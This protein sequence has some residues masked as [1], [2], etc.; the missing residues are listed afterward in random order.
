MKPTLSIL[1]T[2]TLLA[3]PLTTLAGEKL[4]GTPIGTTEGYNYE[5]GGPENN[6][7]YRAFDGDLNT[8]FATDARSYTWVGL[9]LGKPYIIDRIGWSPRNDIHGEKRVQLGVFQGANSPDWLDAV[10]L[11]L[12]TDKGTIGLMSYADIDCSRGFRY[13]RYVST[14]DSRCNIAEIEFYGTEGNGDDSRL[15]QVTNLPTV[16]INTVNAQEPYDKEHDITSN[17]IIIAD[18]KTNVDKPATIRE[19]GNFSRTFP[20]KPW[21]IKFDKKQ[22]VLDAPAKAKKWTLINNYGDKTLMRNLIAFEIARRTGMEYVP[23]GRPVDVI[24]NGEYKGC[25][26]LCDQVEVNDRRVPVTEMETTDIDGDAL[27]GGYMIEIDAYANQE[28]AGEWFETKTRHMPVTIKSPDEGGTPVQYAYIKNYIESIED[29][30]YRSDISSAGDM[31]YR[32]MLDIRSFLQHFI[33]GELTGNTDTYWSTYMYKKRGDDLMYT[34][35]VWDFDIAFENDRRTYP[36]N[37]IR[38]KFLYESGRASSANNMQDFTSRIIHYDTRTASDLTRLW[39]LA[40]NDNGITGESLSEYIDRMADE[41][42]QSQI[43]NFTRWPVMND[44]IHEN[45][46]IEGSYQGEVNRVRNYLK[47]RIEVLDRLMKYDAS[48][49]GTDDVTAPADDNRRLSPVISQHTISL[50]GDTPFEVYSID[51]RMVYQGTGSTG[52]LNS[53]IYLI[54]AGRTTVKVAL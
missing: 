23:Y 25:Y 38:D 14:S 40:R 49:S 30:L 11:Y 28:P 52:R 22:N 42:N 50:D 34:G 5:K 1:I 36:I 47:D 31:D 39:S 29:R 18:N 4:S 3:L 19:R 53:G 32:N 48:I 21:R 8:Y 12:I 54:K 44:Q 9:D 10:P 45:P 33:V 35:P 41:I 16:C 2:T 27:T 7:Q 51:G 43:L 24:L 17:I 46:V 15:F 26:Q 20:K 13:V 6:I 37:D